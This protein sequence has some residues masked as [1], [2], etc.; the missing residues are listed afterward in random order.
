MNASKHT[1]MWE[2]DEVKV[3]VPYSVAGVGTTVIVT[4]KFTGKILLLD[5]G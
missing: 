3:D 5:V 4:S 2:N 1:A